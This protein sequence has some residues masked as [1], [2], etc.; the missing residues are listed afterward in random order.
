M[1][2]RKQTLYVITLKLPN[3]YARDGITR[4]ITGR[5]LNA[6][7][8]GKRK[9]L[10][11]GH[12]LQPAYWCD[13]RLQAEKQSQ[14]QIVELQGS[15]TAATADGT[16]A[17]SEQEE[18]RAA[19]KT[20]EQQQALLRERAEV[21]ESDHRDA[22]AAAQTASDLLAYCTVDEVCN[23]MKIRSKPSGWSS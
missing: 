14:Q 12:L 21:A 5:V 9:C 17:A 2:N 15:L 16:K 23:A 7:P 20:A 6:L 19:H 13:L 8:A 18:L 3:R 4:C 11:W 10:L 1:L 22:Q